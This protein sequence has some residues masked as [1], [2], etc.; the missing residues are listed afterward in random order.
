MNPLVTIEVKG[1]KAEVRFR[2]NGVAVDVLRGIPGG[3]YV[4]EGKHWTVPKRNIKHLQAQLLRAGFEVEVIDGNADWADQ[5]MRRIRCE[6]KLFRR[7]AKALHPDV[8]GDG[9]LMQEL[10]VARQRCCGRS[11]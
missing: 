7:V 6:D 8:D 10:N 11:R 3:L 1:D 5:L 4:P 2:F 9:Q